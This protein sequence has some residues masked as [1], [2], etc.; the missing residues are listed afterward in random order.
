MDMDLFNKISVFFEQ[1]VA[2]IDS[3][4]NINIFEKN[5]PE[6]LIKIKYLLSN[7]YNI[8]EDD[9]RYKNLIKDIFNYNFTN[10]VKLKDE[11]TYFIF[12]L[13]P[14][15]I[16]G[17]KIILVTLT[18]NDEALL[19]I[20]EI[21]YREK[22]L[23]IEK[24]TSRIIHDINNVL[25]GISSTLS[26][27]EF[28]IMKGNTISQEELTKYIN[29]MSHSAQRVTDV[30]DEFRGLYIKNRSVNKG[31]NISLFMGL[32]E[33]NFKDND[34]VKVDISKEIDLQVEINIEEIRNAIVEI[35]KNSIQAIKNKQ[36]IDSDFVGNI[37]IKNG[38][39]IENDRQYVTIEVV[40]N[41]IGIEKNIIE[42]IFEPY[43]SSNNP[44]NGKGLGLTL[45]DYAV[46]K[47]GG[48]IRVFSE[49]GK[50][51]KVIM[52][53]PVSKNEKI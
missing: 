29:T 5:I 22:M 11:D 9:F 4:L 6:N 32:I 46:I 10:R 39:F 7:L 45:A 47:S 24:L 52:Y 49:K 21:D 40:D 27:V 16:E 14:M 44:N 30:L 37:I 2:L 42:N 36:L 8:L 53:L 26:L 25:G 35:V 31:I 19:N 51:T 50:G 34:I 18:D 13:I 1:P 15:K 48:F 20:S 41:G 38:Y 17:E 33:N 3:S 23:P 12:N 43:F 28:K